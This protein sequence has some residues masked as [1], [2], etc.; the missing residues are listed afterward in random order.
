[1]ANMGYISHLQSAQQGSCPS[2]GA[3]ILCP[4]LPCQL[5]QELSP[6]MVP[7]PG[8]RQWLF[9]FWNLIRCACLEDGAAL[10]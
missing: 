9:L 4:R 7:V 10:P 5:Q 6:A 8:P 3:G 2:T 1:M